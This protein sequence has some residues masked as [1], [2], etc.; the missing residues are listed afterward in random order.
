[1]QITVE[2]FSIN[3]FNG[4]FFAFYLKIFLIYRVIADIFPRCKLSKLSE[5]SLLK[6]RDFIEAAG[7]FLC[8][9]FGR[10]QL[11]WYEFSK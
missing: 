1:M 6:K 7:L 9:N 8:W 3:F 4:F 2:M 5:D 11:R 10:L